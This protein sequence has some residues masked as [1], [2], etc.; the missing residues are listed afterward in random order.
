MFFKWY[1]C[2]TDILDF[3]DPLSIS[4]DRLFNNLN[5]IENITTTNNKQNHTGPT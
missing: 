3:C 2:I 4:C 5:M 1:T